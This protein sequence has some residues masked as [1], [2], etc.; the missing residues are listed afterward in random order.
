MPI[1]ADGRNTEQLLRHV[2]RR[3]GLRR[4]IVTGMMASPA[5]TEKSLLYL[6]RRHRGRERRDISS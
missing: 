2:A 3:S 6:R 4:S 5:P 1:A